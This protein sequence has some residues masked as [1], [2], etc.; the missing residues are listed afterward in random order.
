MEKLLFDLYK[1]KSLNGVQIARKLGVHSSTIYRWLAKTGIKYPMPKH[2]TIVI[3]RCLICKKKVIRWK[4]RI[5][6]YCSAQCKIKARQTGKFVKC[7][8]CGKEIYRPNW[9]FKV[10]NKPFCS[11]KCKGKWRRMQINKNLLF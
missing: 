1:R 4:G 9:W 8:W 11:R 3:T 5:V 7:S 10:N 6:K 2:R